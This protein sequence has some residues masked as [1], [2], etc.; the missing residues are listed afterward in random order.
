[1]KIEILEDLITSIRRSRSLLI[2]EAA[3]RE[4]TELEDKQIQGY[5]EVR[6]ILEGILYPLYEA[7]HTEDTDAW[8]Q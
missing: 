7:R 8:E 3:T 5:T 4:L 2:L 6:D 1:M